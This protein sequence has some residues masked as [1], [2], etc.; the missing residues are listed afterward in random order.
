MQQGIPG[1]WNTGFIH[2]I[3]KRVFLEYGIQD[4]FIE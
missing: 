2:G 3:A 4:S 1:I